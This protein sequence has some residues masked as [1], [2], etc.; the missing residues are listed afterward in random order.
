[1]A[2]ELE[3]S[4][5]RARRRSG[6]GAAA[7]AFPRSAQLTSDRGERGRRLTAAAQ[8]AWFAG[9]RDRA[10][11]LLAEAEQLV[12]DPAQRARIMQ[13]GGLFEL[14]RGMPDK[15][16]RLLVDSAAAFQETRLRLSA[17]ET[18][19]LAGEAAAFIGTPALSAEVGALAAA[20]RAGDRRRRTG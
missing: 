6:A 1:M 14:R 7:D 10:A 16:Y 11:T 9:Q 17:L 8:D 20:V 2:A 15:A 5:D 19:V 13:L 12:E 4:A 18:L 3:N